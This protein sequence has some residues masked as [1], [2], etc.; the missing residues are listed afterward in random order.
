MTGVLRDSLGEPLMGMTVI[1]IDAR[2]GQAVPTPVPAEL[3]TSDDRGVYR[4]YG[5]P[6]G[7]YF[8]AT[9]PPA[10]SAARTGALSTNEIE[11]A[12]AALTNRAGGSGPDRDDT[13]LPV[14]RAVHY[15]P[16]FYP[17]TPYFDQAHRLRLESGDERADVNIDV[18]PVLVG[19]IEATA[20][21]DRASRTGLA[22]ELIPAGRVASALAS[23]VRTLSPTN[24]DPFSF[25]NLPPGRYRVVA[26]ANPGGGPRT[27]IVDTP[28]PDGSV[29]KS[30]REFVP[31]WPTGDFLYGLADVDV[32][33]DDRASVTLTLQPGGVI[34]GRLQLDRAST[35]KPPDFSRISLGV[36]TDPSPA[37]TTPRGRLTEQAIFDVRADGS[38]ELRG[39]GPGRFRLTV[40]APADGGV[41]WHARSA[42]LGQR[43][44]LDEWL[45]L[46]PGLSLPDVVIT[47][48]DRRTGLDGMLQTSSGQPTSALHVVILPIDRD[49]WRTGSRRIISARPQS[50]GRFSFDVPPGDYALAAVTDLDPLD[51]MDPAWLE[52]IVGAGVKVTVAEAERTRQD[53]RIK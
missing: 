31:A 33:G 34:S 4:L 48:S 16:M 21:T 22:I 6:P 38:F 17:G 29:R 47:L 52:Q 13:N 12:L 30:V 50:D 36:E 10:V 20:L 37:A 27:E 23:S 11:A 42:R 19:S 49:L 24:A 8:V 40:S 1:A 3:S 14:S 53:L 44:L 32:H 46:G 25:T 45:E 39:I 28:M 35:A 15:A 7:D 26:R 18:T 2:T 51:L 5:L 9:V 43:E 41:R